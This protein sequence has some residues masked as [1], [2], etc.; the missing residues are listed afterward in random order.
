MKSTSVSSVFS[1]RVNP[2]R[3]SSKPECNAPDLLYAFSVASST[4]PPY[5]APPE[6]D[7]VKTP[8]TANDTFSAG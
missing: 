1:N 5:K 2:V 4:F 6:R 7:A 3:I 8:P